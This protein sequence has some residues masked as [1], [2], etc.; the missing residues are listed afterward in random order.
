MNGTVRS[1]WKRDEDERLLDSISRHGP[2]NWTA[3]SMDVGGRNGKQC[4]ERWLNQLCPVLSK[5]TW[6]PHED[7]I[8]MQYHA[9]FGN[10]WSRIRQFL[11]RRS[12]NMLKNRWNYLTK[13]HSPRASSS[14]KT[15]A[16]V[17]TKEQSAEPDPR[18]I[19]DE[20]LKGL[21]GFLTEQPSH[22]NETDDFGF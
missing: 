9:E 12:T 7:A 2:H 15:Q 17:K 22:Q 18:H 14:S 3:I 13:Q 10:S 8:L 1:K 5:T 20:D 16:P 11:P 21:F 19:V 4:R 6:L